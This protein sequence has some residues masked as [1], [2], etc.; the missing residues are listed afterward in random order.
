[1]WTSTNTKLNTGTFLPFMT[2]RVEA[3]E[4]ENGGT[5][6]EIKAGAVA[7]IVESQ[8]EQSFGNLSQGGGCDVVR[9]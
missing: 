9:L 3:I 4:A 5:G 2:V 6:T 1:M 7:E 8:Q